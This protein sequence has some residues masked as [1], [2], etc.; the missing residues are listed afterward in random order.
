MADEIKTFEEFKWKNRIIL[1]FA[2]NI[3]NQQLKE[4]KKILASDYRGQ[5]SRDLITFTFTKNNH[6]DEYF[7][8]YD[9]K[10]GFTL[11]LIGKDGG[12]KMRSSK[13]VSLDEIFSLIDS[14]PMRKQEIKEQKKT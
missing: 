6:K 9:I 10:N 14:M 8:K 12:E 5:I 11:I 1:L 2:D 7:D 3:K 4:Q 13:A